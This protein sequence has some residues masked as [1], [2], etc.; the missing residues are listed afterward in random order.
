MLRC[1][2]FL[3][4]INS[5]SASKSSTDKIYCITDT[6]DTKFWS[7]Y[8]HL[9]SR[10]RVVSIVL[11]STTVVPALL[12]HT[13]DGGPYSSYFAT[14]L[15]QFNNLWQVTTF[16]HHV[17]HISHIFNFWCS[18]SL[19]LKPACKYWFKSTE[20]TYANYQCFC[21]ASYKVL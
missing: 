3:I 5:K 1:R 21:M 4:Q 11:H 10:Y 16:H 14:Q 2:K 19:T 9:V 6:Y 18:C 7:R 17:I 15:P 8:C 20:K 12:D 13:L